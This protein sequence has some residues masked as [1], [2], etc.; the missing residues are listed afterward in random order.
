MLCWLVYL[1][2]FNKSDPLSHLATWPVLILLSESSVWFTITISKLLTLTGQ[3]DRKSC[4]FVRTSKASTHWYGLYRIMACLISVSYMRNKIVMSSQR[5]F[6]R[7]SNWHRLRDM[8]ARSGR[9][10]SDRLSRSLR[11]IPNC[12]HPPA[13][14]KLHCINPFLS[15]HTRR[16]HSSLVHL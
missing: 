6:R 1:I 16:L 2:P 13:Q 8:L 11:H 5:T 7:G 15:K 10:Q 9:V 4:T 12:F 3:A 14:N